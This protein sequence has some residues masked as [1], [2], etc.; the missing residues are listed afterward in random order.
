MERVESGACQ[1]RSRY[2]A[3]TAARTVRTTWL[4]AAALALLAALV[5]ALALCLCGARPAWAD[6]AADPF[7][8]PRVT[9]VAD[10]TYLVEVTLDGGTGRASIESPA[11]VAIRQGHAAL[12]CVWSSPNYDYMVVDGARYLPEVTDGH[13]RFEIPVLA[14][15][16][17]FEVVA[18]TTAMSEPHEITYAITVD[19]SSLAAAAGT[20]P[21]SGGAPVGMVAAVVC[22]VLAAL[23]IVR[24]RNAA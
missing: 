5:W 20:A 14:L 23:Y 15:G 24:R 9:D 1:A 8:G 17:P 21:T 18:D 22:G 6:E 7:A 3:S 12:T 2:V 4:A 11:E 19:A 16:E 13:S 10:G